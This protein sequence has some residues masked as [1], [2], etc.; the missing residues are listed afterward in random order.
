[1]RLRIQLTHWP[2]RA[3]TLTDTPDPKC[4][5]CDGDGGIGHHYGDPETGEYAGTDWEPCTCW[6][7]TRRWVLL[8]LPYWF[9]RTTPSFYSDEP[10]F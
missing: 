1:M 2:R 6:D 5:L 10:P 8:P 9:R 7:D 4:P 3:L